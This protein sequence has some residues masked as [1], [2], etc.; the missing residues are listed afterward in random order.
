MGSPE[1]MEKKFLQLS[2]LA[3]I[4]C[5]LRGSIKANNKYCSTIIEMKDCLD[6]LKPKYKADAAAL[7]TWIATVPDLKDCLTVPIFDLIMQFASPHT[8]AIEYVSKCGN[9]A[10]VRGALK[11][12]I[13]KI[14][15]GYPSLEPKSDD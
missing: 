5:R 7:N 4:A 2:S 3:I 8:N 14:A 13:E 10:D 12:W 11:S 1:L 6:L 9:A 15:E